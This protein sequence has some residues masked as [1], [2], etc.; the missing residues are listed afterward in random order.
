MCKGFDNHHCH[1]KPLDR[2]WGWSVDD[3]MPGRDVPENLRILKK[4]QLRLDHGGTEL[5]FL[6]L[7][8]RL[9]FLGLDRWRWIETLNI[10]RCTARW[11]GQHS[12]KCVSFLMS[13]WTEV[14]KLINRLYLKQQSL[15]VSACICICLCFHI[16]TSPN[17]TTIEIAN[18]NILRFGTDLSRHHFIVQVA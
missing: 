11:W 6:P 7:W 13:P 16:C 15:P 3:V 14:K 5:S 18:Q 8:Q 10:T 2:K 12:K 17:Y 1:N 9:S 4:S